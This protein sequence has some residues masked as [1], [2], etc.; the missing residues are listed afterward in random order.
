MLQWVVLSLFH[1][2]INSSTMI[3]SLFFTHLVFNMACLYCSSCF[4]SYFVG[5]LLWTK[6]SRLRLLII[7]T[8]SVVLTA[9]CLIFN[10]L[11][12]DID[13]GCSIWS[14]LSWYTFVLV[15]LTALMKRYKGTCLT[16]VHLGWM[17]QGLNCCGTF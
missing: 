6:L 9:F 1:F 3:W 5:A 13:P 11:I 17:I 16:F 2:W 14:L 8:H 12:H 15:A 4:W 7:W 10:F